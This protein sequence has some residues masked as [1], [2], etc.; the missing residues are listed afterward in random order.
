MNGDRKE[1]GKKIWIRNKKNKGL[2]QVGRVRQQVA[3]DVELYCG[4][5]NS[6]SLGGRPGE[7][8]YTCLHKS[9]P[10]DP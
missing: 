8:A 4:S 10:D 7:V 5:L 2:T 1:Q 9:C 6:Q 3:L